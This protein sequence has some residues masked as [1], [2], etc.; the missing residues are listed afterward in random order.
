MVHKAQSVVRI[1]KIVGAAL[2]ALFLLM[3][4]SQMTLSAYAQPNTINWNSV[5]VGQVVATG[6]PVQVGNNISCNFS[7]INGV[8]SV[9]QGGA[10]GIVLNVEN[11]CNLVVASKTQGPSPS[12]PGGDP[13]NNYVYNHDP[14]GIVLTSVKGTA[15]V[16]ICGSEVCMS[17]YVESCTAFSDGWVNTAC[18]I[19]STS[20]PGNPATGAGHGDFHWLM[21][22]YQ[23]TL[24]N[25]EDISTDGSNLYL[26]CYWSYSGSIVSG[27]GAGMGESCYFS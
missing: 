7:N 25:S 21:N 26:T 12:T 22:S 11:N 15:S 3:A 17:S 24:Y 27:M 13:T 2:G 16:S 10:K 1:P 23:H 4:V 5:S 19:D 20:S 14:V 18:D 9:T 6:T 8:T